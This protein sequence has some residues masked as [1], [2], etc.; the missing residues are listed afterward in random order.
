LFSLPG[1]S[2]RTLS[3]SENILFRILLITDA[4]PEMTVSW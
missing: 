1:N 4:H 2:G 3:D